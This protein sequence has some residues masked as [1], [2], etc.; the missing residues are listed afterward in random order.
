[1][2]IITK[3]LT[4]Y[5][6]NNIECQILENKNFDDYTFYEMLQVTN[7]EVTYKG[8][9]SILGV[10]FIEND[11]LLENSYELEGL[12]QNED[13]KHSQYASRLKKYREL[14]YFYVKRKSDNKR[15]MLCVNPFDDRVIAVDNNIDIIL[16]TSQTMT[17]IFHIKNK[18]N[19]LLVYEDDIEISAFIEKIMDTGTSFGASDIKFLS[20]QTD[21]KI[22]FN[23]D[24]I[25]GKWI[26]IISKIYQNQLFSS[27]ANMGKITYTHGM[28]VDF[29]IS[30]EIKNIKMIWRVN[31][32]HTIDG[33][34]V[35]LR[36]DKIDSR[37][38][39]LKELG[40][41]N[42]AIL[43]LEKI[44]HYNSGGILITG[45]T[46]QGKTWTLNAL[47]DLL[48]NKFKKDVS[49]LG[50]PI[51]KRIHNVTM[52]Q[53][54]TDAENDKYNITFD[55]F[56]E[57]QLRQNNDVIGLVEARSSEDANKMFG[58]AITDHLVLS[59]IHTT[60]FVSTL[61]RLTDIMNVP[62]TIVGD[63]LDKVISQRLV[64][65][66]CQ[67]CKT[68]KYNGYTV[69]IKGC[70]VCVNGYSGEQLIY[71]KV[72]LDKKAKIMISEKNMPHKI[73]QYLLSKNLV[74]T[75]KE[76]LSKQQKDGIIDIDERIDHE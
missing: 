30:T 25:W 19:Y 67:Q 14:E 17:N 40:F 45:S 54:K 62:H 24:G 38:L 27:L 32:A 44:A 11:Y 68:K 70:N 50:N 21:V 49:L 34:V 72:N 8:I 75:Y 66:L 42:K 43:D 31:I 23:I 3:L 64:P 52:R 22:K 26:G 63:T 51:E 28:S 1:M 48:A 16:V 5:L 39:S 47:L 12:N 29:D 15:F 46:R 4:Y 37:V 18:D 33:G 61:T 73:Y 69:N 6:E 9:A 58:F 20:F 76:S 57:D 65:A 55:S 7:L 2:L 41:N 71:E 10:E 59:T 36:S 35:T 74:D 60:N 53:L 56:L 13:E